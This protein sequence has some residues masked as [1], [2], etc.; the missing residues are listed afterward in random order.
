M[1][2]PAGVEEVV[3]ESTAQYWKPVWAA[4]ELYWKPARQ[5]REG[6]PKMAGTPDPFPAKGRHGFG[7]DAV[8][9]LFADLN[10]A[11]SVERWRGHLLGTATEQFVNERLLPL[12]ADAKPPL[13]DNLRK[14]L[15]QA[16]PRHGR[17]YVRS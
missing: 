12:V 3:M 6:A 15:R 8:S 14:V 17:R 4:L 9:F 13:S 10:R 16:G 2:G 1:A 11:G 5:R 7:A